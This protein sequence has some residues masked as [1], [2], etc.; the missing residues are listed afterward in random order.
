RFRQSRRDKLARSQSTIAQ[1]LAATDNAAAALGKLFTV[2]LV[3]LQGVGGSHRP[4]PVFLPRGIANG[5]CG[6][7]FPEPFDQRVSHFVIDVD[8]RYRRALL[9]AQAIRRTHDPVGGAFEVSI[10]GDDP[11]VFAPH[12][13]AQG[14]WMLSVGHADID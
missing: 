2:A 8:S 3:V 1:T 12:L 6:D 13:S 5:N 4:K 14:P 10:R 11:G 9:S 7:F